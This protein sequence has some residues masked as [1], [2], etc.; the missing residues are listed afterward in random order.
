MEDQAYITKF[1]I[2]F[3]FF[4]LLGLTLGSY[5]C[6]VFNRFSGI[7]I[8]KNPS[9]DMNI[10]PDGVTMANCLHHCQAENCTAA[11][12]SVAH[13][14]CC[15]YHDSIIYVSG[16]GPGE[17]YYDGST[18]VDCILGNSFSIIFYRILIMGPPVIYLSL[19]KTRGRPAENEAMVR[20]EITIH[21][22]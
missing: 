12:M 6:K 21:K 7:G 15:T 5:S 2:L 19:G 13:N 1:M 4:L 3:S 14:A 16:N 22:S 9:C 18:T 20:K 10:F 11:V 8:G 17:L